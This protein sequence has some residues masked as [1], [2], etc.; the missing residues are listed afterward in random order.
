MGGDSDV[1][2]SPAPQGPEGVDGAAR[3]MPQRGKRWRNYEDGDYVVEQVA[4]DGSDLPKGCLIPL[5]GVGTF[6]SVREALT[7]IKNSGDVVSGMQLR[8]AK[9]QRVIQ[10]RTRKSVEVELVE[11]PRKLYK[12]PDPEE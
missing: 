4:P 2:V 12:S 9:V 11:K 1:K 10:A 3:K 6:E 8:V 7:W 5:P